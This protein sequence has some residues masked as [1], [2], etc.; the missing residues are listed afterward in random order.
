MT[1]PLGARQFV[2]LRRH[3]VS[4]HAEAPEPVPYGAVAV[5]AGMPAVDED[6]RAAKNRMADSRAEIAGRERIKLLRRLPPP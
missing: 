4:F 5:E 2:H 6:E 3:R 1:L